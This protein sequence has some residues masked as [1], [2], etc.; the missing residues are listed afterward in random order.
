MRYY[1]AVYIH[2]GKEAFSIRIKREQ[3]TI[4]IF[5]NY[6]DIGFH[7]RNAIPETD[8]NRRVR[9]RA[10]EES[11][12]GTVTIGRTIHEIAHRNLILNSS[13]C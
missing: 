1:Y 2:F 11:R 12:K 8:I 3:S 5:S 4:R 10:S 7:N 13:V 6:Q 9:E